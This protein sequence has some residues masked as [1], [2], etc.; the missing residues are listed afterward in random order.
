MV[1]SQELLVK[2]HS[3]DVELLSD[4]PRVD[5]M[6][7][8]GIYIDT[9]F[10]FTTHI[11]QTAKRAYQ[12]IYLINR[13]RGVGYSG[14][15]LNILYHTLVSPIVQYG[16]TVWGGSPCYMLERLNKCHLLARKFNIIQKYTS[17]QKLVSKMDD[18]L[19]NSIV[20]CDNH[21]L[22]DLVPKRADY[23]QQRLRTRKPPAN[24]PQT[25]NFSIF[26]DRFLKQL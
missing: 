14:K 26:P 6:K 17:I 7:L 10:R 8:L 2:F 4:I 3:G 20:K 24:T 5:T 22:A 18:T 25:Q 11:E 19:F 16:I 23:A 9:N 13:L 1:K 15:E 21:M 12:L